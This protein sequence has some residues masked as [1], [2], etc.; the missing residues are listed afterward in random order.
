MGPVEALMEGNADSSSKSRP[1]RVQSA[2][3]VYLIPD[4]LAF[5]SGMAAQ[6]KELQRQKAN[7]D[8]VLLTSD[9][10]RKYIPFAADFGPVNISIVHRFCDAFVKRLSNY[11]DSLIIYCV[12]PTIACR[13]NACFLLA[14]FMVLRQGWSPE[15]ASRVFQPPILA[16]S[17]EPFCDATRAVNLSI[18]DCLLGLS[19]AAELGWYDH[20]TFDRASYDAL[21]DPFALHIH[22]ICPKLVAFKGPLL[23][24][25]RHRRH[26]ERTFSPSA[27]ALALQR[28]GVTCVLRLNE[29]D[30]YDRLS[31]PPP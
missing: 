4:K 2:E 24:D 6:I 11:G 5:T 31:L 29:P 23:D 3:L 12:E 22:Q 26:G 16:F 13:A 15:Q 9:L 7:D 1:L 25:S 19:R 18:H 17:I 30:T 8:I 21:G 27:Y 14:A 10:H 20:A 28:L